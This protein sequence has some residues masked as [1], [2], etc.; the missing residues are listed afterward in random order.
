MGRQHYSPVELEVGRFCQPQPAQL[1]CLYGLQ[2]TSQ[3]QE[4]SQRQT[5]S[6]RG[7][8]KGQLHE[9]LTVAFKGKGHHWLRTPKKLRGNCLGRGLQEGTDCDQSRKRI[10]GELLEVVEITL[11]F[12]PTVYG[13]GSCP[14]VT[15]A[16]HYLE[17]GQFYRWKTESWSFKFLK[18]HSRHGGHAFNPRTRETGGHSTVNLRPA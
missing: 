2:P 12:P 15:A 4:R 3:V 7:E 5:L 13:T 11:T 6:R 8:E 16:Y 10:R 18:S 14:P 9:V 17:L 1:D